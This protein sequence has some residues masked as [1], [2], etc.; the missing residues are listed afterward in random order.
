MVNYKAAFWFLL[1]LV[2]F[3]NKEEIIQYYDD[4]LKAPISA[5]VADI[6]SGAKELFTP[7]PA[8]SQKTKDIEQAILKY[9][10]LKRRKNGLPALKWDAKLAEIA[11]EHSLDMTQNNFFSHDNL[12]GE[13]PTARAK[14]NNYGTR[15]YLRGGAYMIGIAENIGKMPT[16]QT[17][18]GYVNSDADSIGKAHV[19][20]W[21]ESS[22]HRAN[23]LEQ[24]YDV[25]GVGVAYDGTYYVATQN[26]K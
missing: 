2:V 26:F 5:V 17:T 14:R 9:T 3:V 25:I 18:E 11:R 24:N 10:N 20:N 21:M 19:E 16:G 8:I 23:M 4:S 22:G 6:P 1:F 13:D 7:E 15:K 12:K